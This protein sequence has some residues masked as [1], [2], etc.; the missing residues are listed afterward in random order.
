MTKSC[1]L[2]NTLIT[3]YF[4]PVIFLTFGQLH[5]SAKTL[6]CYISTNFF[7]QN[8]LGKASNQYLTIDVLDTPFDLCNNT[9]TFYASKYFKKQIKT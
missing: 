2:C 8:N 5:N 9:Q 1:Q 4:D 7:V 3:H 6:L